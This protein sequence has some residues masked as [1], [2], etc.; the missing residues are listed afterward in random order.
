MIDVNRML[1]NLTE[2]IRALESAFQPT[3]NTRFSAAA[4]V[5][6]HPR[7]GTSDLDLNFYLVTNPFAKFPISEEFKRLFHT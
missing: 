7:L 4:L 5:T 2:N 3:T 6:Y 1:G